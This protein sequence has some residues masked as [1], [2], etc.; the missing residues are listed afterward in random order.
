MPSKSPHAARPYD[1]QIG[2]KRLGAGDNGTGDGAFVGLDLDLL[3]ARL[4]RGIQRAG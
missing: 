3:Q 4:S 1:N 2:L